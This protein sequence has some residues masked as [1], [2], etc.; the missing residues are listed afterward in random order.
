MFE[1]I[2]KEKFHLKKHNLDNLHLTE[3]H[4]FCSTNVHVPV[5]MN[6]FKRQGFCAHFP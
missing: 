3:A 4:M 5:D 6:G 2:S 1:F